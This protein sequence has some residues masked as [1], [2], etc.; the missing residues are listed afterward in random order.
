MLLMLFQWAGAQT[1][2]RGTVSDPRTGEAIPEVAVSLGLRTAFSNS[3]GFFELTTNLT[4]AEVNLTFEKNGFGSKTVAVQ[5]AGQ[6]TL[7]LGRITLEQ[8]EDIDQTDAE[9]FIP[10]I[11]LTS[12]ENASA[13]AESIS[14][15]LTASR[16]LYVSTAA[17]NF[18][19]ARFRIRGYGSRRTATYFNGVPV[20]D[21]ES[22]FIYWSTW[23]G[24]N[25]VLRNRSIS[26]GLQAAPYAFGDIGGA[27]AI[28][29]RAS[30][31]RKQ[32]RVSYAASNRTYRNRVM[33]TYSTGLTENGWALTL[34]GSRRWAEEGYVPGTLYDAYSYFL[35]VSKTLGAKHE[36]NLTALGA[37]IARGRNSAATAELYDLAGSNF[38]NPFWG[39]QNGEK[40][41]ARTFEGHQPLFILRHDWQLSEKTKLMTAASYQFG[42]SGST[43]L[44]WYDAPDPR[45]DYYRR[46]P[47]FIDN[48]QAAEVEQLLREDE[49]LR[50]INWDLMHR[51]NRS[52]FELIENAN[53]IPGNTISGN[54]AQ[55]I[56]EDRRYD[57]QRFN[58]NSYLESI[59]SDHLLLSG[60]INAQLYRGDNYKL[61]DDLLGADYFLDIDKFAEFDAPDDEDFIQN[62]LERPNRVVRNG[63]RF[64]YDYNTYVQRGGAWMQA[65]FT[66]SKVDF[67]LAGQVDYNRLWRSGNVRN[68][69]FPD[70]SA[71]D[72]EK[73]GFLDYGLKGGATYKIDGRNYLVANA[74][75][76][77]QAPWLRNAF[78][79]PRTR[80]DLVPGLESEKIAAFDGGYFYRG[81]Y[82][83]FRLTGYYTRIED[84]FFNR[85]F[86]LDNAIISEDGST[87]GGFVN[88]IMTDINTRRLGLEIAGEVEVLTGLK[89]NAVAAIGEYTYTNRP[90]VAVFLDNRAEKLREY[91]T[92]IKNFHIPNTPQTAYSL[93]L[94][95]RSKRYWFANLNFNYF[96]NI[97][98]DFNP[99][100][101]TLDAVSYVPDP[102]FQEQLVEP[103]SELW[104][105]IIDQ[106]K[107][108]SAFTIDFFGGKSW[109]IGDD[110]FLYLNV[111]VNNILDKKDFITGGYEQFRFDYEEKNVDL[112]PNRYFYGFGRNF[113]A[114]LAVRI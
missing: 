83:K 113:F 108:P 93:G 104:R 18:G 5:L 30:R 91:S 13:G 22:G 82:A 17:F 41:N 100:R 14:G 106:E 72:S 61:V 97:Y 64:D 4:D 55:Y 8:Q 28:D 60:G 42:R 6:A 33:A 96:D 79:S 63:D 11:T 87:E 49:A 88:Y 90:N 74:A 1:I 7:D 92:Y 37:P 103:G 57:A 48:E 62:D 114:Q 9:D 51:V 65:D 44:N 68:G 85:S 101:R 35:S 23:G 66:L 16:D 25:D 94:N 112:F 45:P 39:Y 29:T 80:N 89:V 10:T 54:R 77:T 107:A 27:N 98:L 73:G 110:L 31:Q 12:D 105:R 78:I 21:P 75:Y 86:Y 2:L 47:S 26:V 69:K 50:Q 56:L 70:N 40:R 46:L 19:A 71:G 53:G 58:F 32:L 76:L 67:F 3:E 59:V 81:P 24:L 109:K 95:Y 15:L 43:A 38:Y 99:D 36:L 52:N 84:Q 111:G 20:N 102:S 34:S